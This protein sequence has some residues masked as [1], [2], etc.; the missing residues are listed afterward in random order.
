STWLILAALLQ[1]GARVYSAGFSTSVSPWTYLLNQTIMLVRYLRLTVWPSALVVNYGWP[2]S[3][4]LADV[5]PYAL[6]VLACLALT[7][8]ALWRRPALGSLGAWFFLTL[9]PTTSILPI[10]TEVGAERRMYLPLV[11]PIA[12][13]VIGLAWMGRRRPRGAAIATTLVALAA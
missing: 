6:V 2:R 8:A 3:L 12:L 7:V 1:T 4:T 10:A 11:A 5:L 13:A 9:A